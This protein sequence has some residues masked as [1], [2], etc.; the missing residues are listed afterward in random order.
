MLLEK[1][2]N[3]P[4]TSD[5]TFNTKYP[6]DETK[7]NSKKSVNK[8]YSIDN[9]C[10]NWLKNSVCK[11]TSDNESE[12]IGTTIDPIQQ[13]DQ[14]DRFKNCHENQSNLSQSNKLLHRRSLSENIIPFSP[15]TTPSDKAR[16]HLLNRKSS[17][18]NASSDTLDEPKSSS[19]NTS[20]NSVDYTIGIF[21]NT[22]LRKVA[23]TMFLKDPQY[24]PHMNTQSYGRSNPFTTLTQLK[25]VKK[26]I[27]ASP[28][29]YTAG[30]CDLFSSCFEI[31]VTK[32]AVIFPQRNTNTGKT[33]T[34]QQAK[35]LPSSP[36]ISQR[37]LPKIDKSFVIQTSSKN[38]NMNSSSNN[39]KNSSVIERSLDDDV[40][41]VNKTKA[42]DI[43]KKMELLDEIV[44]TQL[45]V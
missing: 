30:A 19:S 18:L 43:S 24:K 1:Y 5:S 13:F 3:M 33:K 44:S 39:N 31:C 8:R 17:Q 15:H 28:S 7:A 21:C 23:E 27:G 25:G 32:D 4:R 40:L 37:K 45:Q 10:S 11:T 38:M 26:I 22:T 14:S 34:V 12:Q 16:C 6:V 41:F 35:S 42:S 9:Y 20:D 29:T 36:K 2:N